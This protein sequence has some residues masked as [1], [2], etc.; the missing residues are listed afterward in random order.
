VLRGSRIV[1]DVCRAMTDKNVDAIKPLATLKDLGLH[2]DATLYIRDHMSRLK[3]NAHQPTPTQS[4][5][6]DD[7][8]RFQL[9]LVGLAS[10]GGRLA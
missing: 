10:A 1:R 3:L 5:R 4:G 7:D 6:H 9:V 2:L 8:Q